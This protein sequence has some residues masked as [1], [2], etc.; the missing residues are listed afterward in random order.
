MY[1]YHKNFLIK[2]QEKATAIAQ[3][4]ANHL[5][6]KFG[7]ISDTLLGDEQFNKIIEKFNLERDF[8]IDTEWKVKENTNYGTK[9]FQ[10]SSQGLQD[11]ICF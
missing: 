5:V 9:E 7:L 4:F 2:Q 1:Q 10:Y 11:I 6:E 3:E 8:V